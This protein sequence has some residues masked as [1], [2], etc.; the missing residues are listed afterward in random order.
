MI[1]AYCAQRCFLLSLPLLPVPSTPSPYPS[2]TEART[3]G[4]HLPKTRT[5]DSVQTLLPFLF[6]TIG[7]TR[8]ATRQPRTLT[9]QF[10]IIDYFFGFFCFTCVN[11][12]LNLCYTASSPINVSWAC[13][14]SSAGV[15]SCLTY[16]AWKAM[17]LD[18][19]AVE[20]WDRGARP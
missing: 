17:P 5:G 14:S 2:G 18:S 12:I 15:R 10:D 7:D 6:I 4:M 16:E 3:E 1:L 11:T 9:C 8:S 19:N 20:G 13:V